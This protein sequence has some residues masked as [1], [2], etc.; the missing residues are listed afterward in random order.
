MTDDFRIV[1][2]PEK[3]VER[4]ENR[5]DLRAYTR[6][7]LFQIYLQ[8][9]SV[10]MKAFK[11]SCNH[12]GLHAICRV[13]SKFVFFL[14]SNRQCPISKIVVVPIH[15]LSPFFM[16]ATSLGSVGLVPG[17]DGAKVFEVGGDS[18]LHIFCG[19]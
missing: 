1:Q 11:G 7:M 10:I 13:Q 4:N 16:A 2:K 8:M 15:P 5:I 19:R 17:Q 12:V 3:K 18:L 9:D 14:P 6:S